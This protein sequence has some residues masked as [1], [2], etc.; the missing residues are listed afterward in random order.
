LAACFAADVLTAHA[1][2]S[3]FLPADMTLHVHVRGKGK[4]KGIPFSSL[5]NDIQ[6]KIV[7][8][9]KQKSNIK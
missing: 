2:K 5:G 6:P 9:F 4:V 3:C 7:D 8:F 1:H